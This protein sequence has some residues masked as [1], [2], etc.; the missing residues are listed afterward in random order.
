MINPSRP[1]AAPARLSRAQRA[2]LASDRIELPPAARRDVRS[3]LVSGT[4]LTAMLAASREFRFGVSVLR[5]GHPVNVFGTDRP[6]DH[7]QGRAF[8][9][10][11]IRGRAVVDARTPRRLVT[12]FMQAAAA[13]GSYNVGGPTCWAARRSGSATTPTTTTCTQVSAGEACLG[14]RSGRWGTGGSCPD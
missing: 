1:G 3:G 6:S 13:A 5:S 4:V 2:V 9:T 11:S 12:E 10:W 14:M 7:P 8:D